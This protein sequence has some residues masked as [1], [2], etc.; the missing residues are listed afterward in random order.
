MQ[1]SISLV[2]TLF[3]GEFNICKRNWSKTLGKVKT[4]AK[5][6]GTRHLSFVN[7]G[8]SVRSSYFKNSLAI[9]LVKETEQQN[10]YHFLESAPPAQRTA[11]FTVVP[12][13]LIRR[14]HVE[15][16][17][18][19]NPWF[20]TKFTFGLFRNFKNRLIY[21]MTAVTKPPTQQQNVSKEL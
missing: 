13:L 10:H 5:C 7:I 20:A 14:V 12:V 6:W 9:I 11:V 19:R 17:I 8:K 3:G 15:L 1:G 4:L 18:R 21:S 2:F 16:W